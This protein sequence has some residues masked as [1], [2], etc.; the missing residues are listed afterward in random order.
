[1]YGP[2]KLSQIALLAVQQVYYYTFSRYIVFHTMR[3][4]FVGC[5]EDFLLGNYSKLDSLVE[6]GYF[7][8]FY[9]NFKGS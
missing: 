3:L 6:E 7:R 5:S 1:M 9:Q 2:D 8:A 4:S